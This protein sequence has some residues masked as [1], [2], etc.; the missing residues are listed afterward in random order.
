MFLRDR[1]RLSIGTGCT[2]YLRILQRQYLH[3]V[4]SNEAGKDIYFHL[5]LRPSQ[6]L[7]LSKLVICVLY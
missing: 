3:Y 5:L 4:K 1:E 6:I 2:I 7:R